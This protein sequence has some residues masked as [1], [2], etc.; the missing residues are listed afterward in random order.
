MTFPKYKELEF[1]YEYDF[2]VDGG[3]VGNI[4]LRA[5]GNA[6]EAGLVIEDVRVH[7]ETAFDDAGDTATVILGPSGGDDDGYLVDFMSVAEVAGSSVRI[8]QLNGALLWD[9]TNDAPLSY[10]P[11]TA[12]LAIP[13]MKVGTEALTQGKATF[14]FKCRRFS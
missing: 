14:I 6:M 13:V 11:T 8:G 2:S 1:Y 9:T 4:P 5:I 7:V 10:K 3:A 12:T